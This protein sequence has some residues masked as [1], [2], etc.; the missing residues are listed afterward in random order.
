VTATDR[1]VH[2]LVGVRRGSIGGSSLAR[3]IVA[4]ASPGVSPNA[5]AGRSSSVHA[6]PIATSGV[7]RAMQLVDASRAPRSRSLNSP[8]DARVTLRALHD[9]AGA[10]AAPAW[11]GVA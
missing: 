7:L 4:D 11:R 9:H 3:G 1:V 5:C 8:L 6:T 10:A 2:G